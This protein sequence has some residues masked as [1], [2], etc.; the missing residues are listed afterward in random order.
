MTPFFVF[1]RKIKPGFRRIIHLKWPG[2]KIYSSIITTLKS[3]KILLEN[4]PRLNII[5]I[6]DLNPIHDRWMHNARIAHSLAL[7]V[8]I[9]WL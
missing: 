4:T 5:I 3:I 9:M 1:L 7:R 6:N 2:M 8:T